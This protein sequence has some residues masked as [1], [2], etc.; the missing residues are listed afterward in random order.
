MEMNELPDSVPLNCNLQWLT[1]IFASFIVLVGSSLKPF[2]MAQAA[3]H[4]T[5]T[6]LGEPA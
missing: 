1:G 6:A 2:P 4:E 3:G 5:A